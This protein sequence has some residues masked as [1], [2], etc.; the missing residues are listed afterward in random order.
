MTRGQAS[1]RPRGPSSERGAVLMTLSLT[2]LVVLGAAALAI[3]GGLLF[4]QKR[5]AQNAADHAALAAAW[6]DCIGGVPDDAAAESVVKNGFAPSELQ[7]T[8]NP[9]SYVAAVSTSAELA[10]ADAIGFSRVDV[11]ATAEAECVITNAVGGEGVPIDTFVWVSR[12]FFSKGAD[13]NWDDIHADGEECEGG[14]T[15]CY[16]PVFR[17][18]LN[19]DH[20]HDGGHGNTYVA[21]SCT[22][23]GCSNIAGADETADPVGAPYPEDYTDFVNAY[24]VGFVVK[25]SWDDACNGVYVITSDVVA[26]CSGER[27]FTII[28]TGAV[29]L[30]GDTLTATPAVPGILVASFADRS[31][32]DAGAGGSG[33]WAVYL[34][35]TDQRTHGLVWAPNGTIRVEGDGC[36]HSGAFA[37]ET[38]YALDRSC[39]YS[40]DASLVPPSP[41]SPSAGRALLQR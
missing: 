2:F 33:G 18:N 24:T 11:V 35:A 37:G 40:F 15:S 38:V 8:S 12:W 3:D 39:S 14:G 19:G 20:I 34:D 10:F 6:A 30:T 41:V 23:P 25:S 9:P 17:G 36:T 7:L 4:N 31:M 27:S 29:R 5:H 13:S 28:T 1:G 32:Y 26:D 22:Q 21:L 16:G